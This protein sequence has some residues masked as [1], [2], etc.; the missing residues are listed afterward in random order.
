MSRP[1]QAPVSH[2]RHSLTYGGLLA[3]PGARAAFAAAAVARVSF[4][5]ASL[6]LLLLIIPR[7][8]RSRRPGRRP[9]PSPRAR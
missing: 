4:G 9:A 6:S 3:L 1:D 7:P 8:G 5:M 2:A